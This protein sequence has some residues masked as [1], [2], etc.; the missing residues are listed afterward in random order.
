MICGL[1]GAILS[2]G[3]LWARLRPAP[4]R[5]AASP[6]S[7]RA[8]TSQAHL[9]RAAGGA[10]AARR[11]RAS[12]RSDRASRCA[13]SCASERDRGARCAPGQSFEGKSARSCPMARSAGR[14]GYRGASRARAGRPA[15]A[16]AVALV[17][18]AALLAAPH[19]CAREL[20][21]RRGRRRP[22]RP[23]CATCCVNR[24]V[25]SLD[26]PPT[27]RGRR[28]DG[29]AR[30]GC[31]DPYTTYL[32]AAAAIAAVRGRD[33]TPRASAWASR[34]RRA[35]A[36]C[37][38]SAPSTARRPRR[39]GLGSGDAIL[40]IDGVSIAALDL[41]RRARA[42]AGHAR[43]RLVA[44]RAPSGHRAGRRPALVRATVALGAVTVPRRRAAESGAC[45]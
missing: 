14:V 22:R 3:L 28:R 43:Q 40:A 34:S 30:R 4:A 41:R 39:R 1:V 44:A 11:H 9:V 42:P 35:P 38:C 13:A 29:D 45:A 18:A 19:R 24:Y 20:M 7:S 5:L 27:R 12:E 23:R 31:G 15:A 10:P 16:G 26:A 32:P 37:A 21:R 33:A 8:T 6:R 36:A 2:V 25:R 17:L